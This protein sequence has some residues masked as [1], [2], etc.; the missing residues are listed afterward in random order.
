MNS[1]K[2]LY[3]KGKNDECLTLPY[4]VAPIIKY[5]PK[6]AT[7]WCP[8][9]IENSEFVKQIRANGNKVIASHII[10]GQ[11]FY[12]Y[13][14]K[15]QWDCIVSN[16]PFGGKRKIFERALSFNKPFALIAPNT[17]WNDAAP[18]QIFKDK[19]LQI[20]SF[21]YRMKF[22]NNGVIEKKIT[23]MS[24]YWCWNFLPKQIIFEHLS[25]KGQET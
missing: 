2:V 11:D 4:G 17:W 19:D 14:P 13:E 15:E 21:D 10:N 18:A 22:E 1:K 24:A 7:V 16:P 9:D 20:L 12:I 5:I 8:F 3:S 25:H 6:S 23:F